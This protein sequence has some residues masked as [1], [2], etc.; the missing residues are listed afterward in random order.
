MIDI[1]IVN[2]TSHG[3]L[4]KCV[5]SIFNSNQSDLI[6]NVIIIDNNSTDDSLQMLPIN[7][8]IKVIKNTE[9]VGFARACNQGFKLSQSNY[10]LLLNP[11]AVLLENTISESFDYMF[12][13][14]TC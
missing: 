11:D 5:E 6:S 1:V 3:F 13:Y 4:R 7:A 10:I 2:W 9:N 12:F 14:E 8:K